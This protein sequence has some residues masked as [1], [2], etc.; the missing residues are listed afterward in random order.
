MVIIK[1]RVKKITIK[2][3]I[4]KT[5]DTLSWDFLLNCLKGLNLSE[6]LIGWL[7]ECICITSFTLGY[8]GVVYGF[9]KGRR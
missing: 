8:N 6:I 4:A 3:D 2:V 7:K 1:T 5:F 9:F